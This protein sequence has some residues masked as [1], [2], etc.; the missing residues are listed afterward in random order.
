MQ[1]RLNE[2]IDMNN[3]ENEKNVYDRDLNNL[4]WEVYI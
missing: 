2:L 4:E 3:K 1:N